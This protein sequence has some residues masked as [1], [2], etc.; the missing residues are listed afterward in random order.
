MARAKQPLDKAASGPL[1]KAD[2]LKKSP[3]RNDNMTQCVNLTESWFQKSETVMYVSPW[4]G[5][6]KRY[7]MCIR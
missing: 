3:E 4:D 5:W 1:P 7:G 6:E 2:G